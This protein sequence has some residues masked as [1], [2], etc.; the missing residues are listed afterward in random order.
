MFNKLHMSWQDLT[1]DAIH[2]IDE[3]LNK[4]II[5]KCMPSVTHLVRMAETIQS[6][7]T[8][9]PTE[10]VPAMTEG[11]MLLPPPS[12][13]T[14]TCVKVHP[15][16]QETGLVRVSM[17]LSSSTSSRPTVVARRPRPRQ[18]APRPPTR[19]RPLPFELPPDADYE[20]IDD[21]DS[22]SSSSADG[23]VSGFTLPKGYVGPPTT[24]EAILPSPIRAPDPHPLGH[25]RVF[26]QPPEKRAKLSHEPQE[27]GNLA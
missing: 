24:Q 14:K 6:P 4:E 2:L 23:I 18:R 26:I 19:K 7:I 22:S 27:G 12:T 20:D 15:P 9:G 5:I 8:A 17:R 3:K 11:S 16:D 10:D 25:L 21:E 13:I 1:L